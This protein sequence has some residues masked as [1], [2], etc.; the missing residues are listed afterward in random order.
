MSALTLLALADLRPDDDWNKARRHGL[1]VTKGIMAFVATAYGRQYAP[2]TRETFR[3]QVLH[4]FIQAHIADYN[5]FAP[6]LPTNS[7]HAHY[8]LSEDALAAIRAYGTSDWI[9]TS[10]QFLEQQA[11]LITVYQKNRS[12]ALIPV[13]LPDS[14][15]LQLSPGKHNQ[16]Q[17]AIV[18]AF[19]PRFA[20]GADVLYLGDTANKTLHL[21]AERLAALCVF[22]PEHGKL[23][24]VILFD[25][26]RN[27]LF[28][29]EAVAAHGPM[30]SK[31]V[32]ELQE[33]LA[34]C[35]AR[36]VFVSAFRTM[37]EFRRHMPAIAWETEVWIAD[38]PDHLI[39]FNGDDFLG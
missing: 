32:A 25:S 17:A 3:R 1:T 9:S 19:A 29:I 39:H 8:A 4:Q 11:T 22:M 5:P 21:D 26:E 15:V 27:R 24:D 18:Q 35:Q 38:I 28:L 16:L 14:V 2:N 7:P 23:P 37:A 20:S 31:R 10:S 33:M 36:P 34:N 6:G 30:T 13:R 12:R